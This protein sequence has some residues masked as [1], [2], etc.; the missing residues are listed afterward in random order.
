MRT[1]RRSYGPFPVHGSPPQRLPNALGCQIRPS[2]PTSTGCLPPEG[3]SGMEGTRIHDG[4]LS[5]RR[6]KAISAIRSK[7]MNNKDYLS[8]RGLFSDKRNARRG[9][10]RADWKPFPLLGF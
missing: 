1:V 4:A 9:R 6:T 5:L 10:G 3:S 2:E 8:L 7:V